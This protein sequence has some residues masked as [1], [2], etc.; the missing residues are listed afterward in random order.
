MDIRKINMKVNI[1][2][3]KQAHQR[4]NQPIV[5]IQKIWIILSSNMLN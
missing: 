2:Y 4:R 1:D 3:A 5:S